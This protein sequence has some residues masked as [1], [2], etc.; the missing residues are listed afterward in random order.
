MAKRF[1]KR[2]TRKF[3]KRMFKKKYRKFNKIPRPLGGFN[4]SMSVKFKYS[5]LMH[6]FTTG[7]ISN[8]VFRLNSLY[9]PD[10]TGAG[11]QPLYLD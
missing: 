9:D 1:F 5:Y 8:Q 4:N 6:Q 11:G 2:T 10:Y 7:T 3:K